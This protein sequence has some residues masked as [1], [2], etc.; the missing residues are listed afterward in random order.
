VKKPFFVNLLKAAYYKFFPSSTFAHKLFWK[1]RFSGSRLVIDGSIVDS[2]L[3]HAHR[4]EIISEFAKF[5]NV[6]SV[7]ELGSSWGANLLLIRN[8]YPDVRFLGVDISK[9]M[10]D[11]GNEYYRLQNIENIKLIQKDMTFLQSF[12]DD[13]F[14]I[15]ISDAS[16]IYID[17]KRIKDLAV[18]M[19]R[20]AKI[21]FIIV[22]FDDD[23]KDSAGRVLQA[24]WIR[25]YKTVFQQFSKKI[26]KRSFNENVW[27]G[28]WSE[29]GKIITV[30]LN[31]GE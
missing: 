27:P 9:Q 17:N 24:N 16:L 22:A 14:D 28:K 20:I 25:D 11:S 29:Y 15:I 3:K 26:E 30:F 7:L 12:K 2:T 19:S 13:E 31:K 18:E 1:Y 8:E 21:G 4:L 23:S 6:K 10:V 5:T